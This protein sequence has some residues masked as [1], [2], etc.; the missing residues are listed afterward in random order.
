M[1]LAHRHWAR[2]RGEDSGGGGGGGGG[3][4]ALNASSVI[5]SNDQA[6]G[7]GG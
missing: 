6:S 2:A 3:G 4:K 5:G 7:V 1:P